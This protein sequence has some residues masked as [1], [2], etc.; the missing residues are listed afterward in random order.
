MLFGLL[1]WLKLWNVLQYI[2]EEVCYLNG[3]MVITKITSVLRIKPLHSEVLYSMTVV[4]KLG[5]IISK[6]VLLPALS[7]V[8]IRMLLPGNVEGNW[9]S[10]A[11]LMV[12]SSPNHLQAA[13]I[14]LTL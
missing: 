6:S 3:I 14:M 13:I 4:H 10:N 8:S 1:S 7:R 2:S 11:L 12:C 5:V 9:R